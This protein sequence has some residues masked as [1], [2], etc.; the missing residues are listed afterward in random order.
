MTVQNLALSVVELEANGASI[1]DTVVGDGFGDGGSV[2]YVIA[3]FRK[4]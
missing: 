2:D 1:A 3:T 4:K